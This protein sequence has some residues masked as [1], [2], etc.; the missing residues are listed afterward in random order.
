[1]MRTRSLA[2][3]MTTRLLSLQNPDGGWGATASRP[4]NTEA[5][6]F[7]VLALAGNE[8]AE[9]GLE[10]LASHQRQ[11]GSWP[12][13]SEID[14]PSWASSQAVLALAESGAAPEA[15]DRGVDW[16]ARL[17]G[18]TF[19]WRTRL[20]DW[21]RGREAVELDSTLQGWPWAAGTFS[22]IEPTAFAVLALE[23]ASR[24]H[25]TRHVRSRIREAWKMIV[26]RECPG[27]GWNYGNSRVLGVDME[28][29]PDTTAL[30]L[31]ALQG[32]DAGAVV[33]RGFHVLERLVD[34]T[35]SGL[36]FSL[37][38]LCR[39]AWGLDATPHL[40]GLAARFEA[41]GFLDDTRVIALAL[42]AS[43][44]TAALKVPVDD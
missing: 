29:F 20:R 19:D 16:L 2:D 32:A 18:R 7:S 21:L 6:S 14:A 30:A 27:G 31:L 17:K 36:A 28:P 35:K 24:G 10:W 39:Q 25:P 15:I 9:A 37:G 23:R 44:E 22:W 8:A 42:L 1:M 12:W 3:G 26:D 13:T 38:A 11:D 34:A 40:D 43:R 5:T 41:D 33:D 4:S